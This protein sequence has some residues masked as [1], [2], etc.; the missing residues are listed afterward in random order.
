MSINELAG[1]FTGLLLFNEGVGTIRSVF[2]EL[3]EVFVIAEFGV[4]SLTKA[5]SFIIP[6][7]IVTHITR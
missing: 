5:V 4:F 6:I 3:K 7:S 2:D 1:D